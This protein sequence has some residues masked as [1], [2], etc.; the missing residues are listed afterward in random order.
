MTSRAAFSPSSRRFLSIILLRSCA[1][2]SSVLRV[3]PIFFQFQSDCRISKNS[4]R[5]TIFF[6]TSRKT[7][8]KSYRVSIHGCGVS[9][10]MPDPKRPRRA[11]EPLTWRGRYVTYLVCQKNTS[12][13]L[14]LAL[15]SAFRLVNRGRASQSFTEIRELPAAPQTAH[16]RHR[17]K[18]L[19]KM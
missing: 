11:L 5:R 9:L 10:Q 18:P 14:H 1:A 13:L 8:C 17:N 12:L 7:T 16:A 6:F 2:L 19:L 15:R 3:H 4:E